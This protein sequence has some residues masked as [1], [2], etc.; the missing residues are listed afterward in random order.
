MGGGGTA[1]GSKAGTW[2]PCVPALVFFKLFYYFFYFIKFFY[3]FYY[4][5][6]VCSF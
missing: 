1:G 3:I 2:N 4:Y 6:F 5:Y